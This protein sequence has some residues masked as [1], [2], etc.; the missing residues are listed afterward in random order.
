MA[1]NNSQDLNSTVF[2][3]ITS[4]V[5][6]VIVSLSI[7]IFAMSQKISD[8]TNLIQEEILKV[9]HKIE[10]QNI[11]LESELKSI[12]EKQ[13]RDFKYIVD[14]FVKKEEFIKQRK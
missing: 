14:N 1:I 10:L 7:F 6:K 5:F 13:D 4:D 9:N 2:K 8:T 3:I 12:R 11:I